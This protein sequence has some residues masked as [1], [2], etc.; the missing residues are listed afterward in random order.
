MNT[1]WIIDLILTSIIVWCAIGAFCWF[2][3]WVTQ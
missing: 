3:L 2:L 1:R